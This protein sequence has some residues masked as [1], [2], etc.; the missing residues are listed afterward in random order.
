MK[1]IIQLWF[2]INLAILG[3]FSIVVMIPILIGVIKAIIWWAFE[4]LPFV[5]LVLLVLHIANT[6]HEIITD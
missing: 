6:L 1:L 3:L 5:F 4:A 2:F